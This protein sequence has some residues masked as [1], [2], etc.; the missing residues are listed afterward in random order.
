MKSSFPELYFHLYELQPVTALNAR[1]TS[2]KRQGVLL[3]SAEGGI[4][5]I[6]PWPEL[7]D[8]SLLCELQAL[9]SQQP[10]ALG[11]RTLD[12]LRADGL[13]RQR[14]ESLFS[15]GLVIPDSHATLPAN[16]DEEELLSFHHAGF[17]T[18]KVK[19]PADSS[20]LIKMLSR[21]S[22]LLPEWSWRIDFNQTLVSDQFTLLAKT[23]NDCTKGRIDF[24]E[25]PVPYDEYLW[26]RWQQEG[27]VLAADRLPADPQT[28]SP[29]PLRVW[30]P[31]LETRECRPAEKWIVTS[32]MDHPVGQAWAAYEAACLNDTGHEVLLCGL[33]TQ[34]LYRKTAFSELMGGP[35]PVF[36]R[37]SGT[38]LGFD[39]LIELVPWKKLA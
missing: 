23:L 5:C 29:L 7:G 6:Q 14:G 11:K 12:C 3:R 17:R 21:W 26:G 37:L 39:D 25:D 20:L 31:A 8:A 22:G 32:Y 19:A 15:S 28:G 33:V 2:E 34:H 27:F 4:A 10:L 38:G 1:S 13:A 16:P 18:G 9:K 24:F 30:K 35:S 36:P